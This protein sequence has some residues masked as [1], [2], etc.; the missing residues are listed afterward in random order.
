MT[1]KTFLKYF[2]K[3]DLKYFQNFI[4][5]IEYFAV[6]LYLCHKMQPNQ[7]SSSTKVTTKVLETA[8][9]TKTV[10]LVPTTSVVNIKM[11]GLLTWYVILWPGACSVLQNS[12][13]GCGWHRIAEID[14]L[15]MCFVIYVVGKPKRLLLQPYCNTY[16]CMC[17]TKHI[18]K[19]TFY[20][21]GQKFSKLFVSELTSLQFDWWRVGLLTNYPVSY[22]GTALSYTSM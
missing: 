4:Y 22:P 1:L 6:Y 13:T 5:E 2:E 16:G 10:P 21:T 3:A 20:S 7:S 19:N 8:I 14:S 17:Y 11:T 15:Q 9:S 12:W 18:L